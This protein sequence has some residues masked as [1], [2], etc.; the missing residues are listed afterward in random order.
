V[1]RLADI[2]EHIPNVSLRTLNRDLTL[3]ESENLIEKI[4]RGKNVSY[5]ALK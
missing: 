2:V 1:L 4:G 5:Q 3:L